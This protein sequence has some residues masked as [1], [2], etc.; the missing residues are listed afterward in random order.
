MRPLR[1]RIS[2]S[3][4]SPRSG[5]REVMTTFAPRGR[6]ADRG[7]LA[8]PRVAAGDDDD[9]P[10]D[11]TV[12]PVVL[13]GSVRLVVPQVRAARTATIPARRMERRNHTVEMA[14]VTMVITVETIVRV[15]TNTP[16]DW[17]SSR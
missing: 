4:C 15:T 11:A 3:A 16:T 17:L 8:D 2:A 6:E 1:A 13:H 7:L 12:E 14:I 10:V 9:A 5:L